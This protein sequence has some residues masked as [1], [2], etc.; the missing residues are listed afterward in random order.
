MD[1]RR[2][3]YMKEFDA[4]KINDFK[5]E[6]DIDDNGWNC[7]IIKFKQNKMNDDGEVKKRRYRWRFHSVKFS[8]VNDSVIFI[9]REKSP[10][11]KIVEKEVMKIKNQPGFSLIE[12][13]FECRGEIYEI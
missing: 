4:K 7:F 13:L 6:Q 3:V 11:L 5:V 12:K 9:R 8:M 10:S 1:D 2:G